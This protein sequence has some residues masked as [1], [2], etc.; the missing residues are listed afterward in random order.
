MSKF[1]II[2]DYKIDFL[3]VKKYYELE[4]EDESDYNIINDSIYDKCNQNKSCVRL[5]QLFQDHFTEKGVVFETTVR[6]RSKRKRRKRLCYSSERSKKR[7]KIS[8]RLVDHL[9]RSIDRSSDGKFVNK[10]IISSNDDMNLKNSHK[11]EVILLSGQ[12]NVI[13]IINN[14]RIDANLVKSKKK[15][16]KISNNKK[17]N[18]NCLTKPKQDLNKTVVSNSSNNL[19]NQ[20]T[21]CLETNEFKTFM[22]TRFR[23]SDLLRK[24]SYCENSCQIDELT[25]AFHMLM[26]SPEEELPNDLRINYNLDSDESQVT[27]EEIIGNQINSETDLIFNDFNVQDIYQQTIDEDIQQ[28]MDPSL[29][30]EIENFFRNTTTNSISVEQSNGLPFFDPLLIPS[31]SGYTGVTNNR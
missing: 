15:E 21:N 2:N 25:L 18:N 14:K 30:A 6:P 29:A 26:T 28:N 16:P 3:G 31:T 9:K 1:E 19:F 12:N 27:D 13:N 10:T 23:S 17:K 22:G 4:S 24:C 20:N 7:S 8:D 11:Q 5:Q